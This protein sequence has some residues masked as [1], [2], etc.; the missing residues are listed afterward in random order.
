MEAED[1]GGKEIRHSGTSLVGPRVGTQI[2]QIKLSRAH[3][4]IRR[5]DTTGSAIPGELANVN[6]C[7]SIW[8]LFL[9]W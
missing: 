1:F 6:T 8:P 3:S 9:T 4:E 7:A 5:D 2:F